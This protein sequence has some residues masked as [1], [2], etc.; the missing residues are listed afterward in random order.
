[1]KS[2]KFENDYGTLK[3]LMVISRRKYRIWTKFWD[4]N[5]ILDWKVP[6]I[7]MTMVS[8]SPKWRFIGKILI[9]IAKKSFL[10]KWTFNFLEQKCFFLFLIL[11]DLEY[12]WTNMILPKLGNVKSISTLCDAIVYG[13][14]SGF[15]IGFYGLQPER[16]FVWCLI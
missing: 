9:Y 1:M 2:A 4:D 10:V 12:S 16:S 13:G 15:L 7:K 3:S 14:F 6:N 11:F 8:L 5:D